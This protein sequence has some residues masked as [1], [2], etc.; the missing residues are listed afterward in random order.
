MTPKFIH[1]RTHSAYSVLEGAMK[2]GK[3]VKRIKALN[4]P[5]V[6]VTD[7]GNLYCGMDFSHEAAD[8]GI[9]PILGT[10]LLLK[11]PLEKSNSLI[12]Q[13]DAEPVLD[14][15]VLLVQNEAGYKNLLKIFQRYYMGETKQETP[16][17][18]VEELIE[19]NQGLILL[20]GGATGPIGRYILQGKPEKAKELTVRLKE[21]FGNRFYM[22]VSRTGEADE[23]KTEATFLDLAYELEI[24]LVAT[25]EAFYDK[26][27]MYEAHDA[28]MC[29]G[30]KTY[31]EVTDRIR[32]S[33]QHYLKSADE[34]A[35]LFSDLPEA[36]EN[37]VKIAQRC[38]FMVEFH[39]PE[40]PRYDCHG[41]TEDEVLKATNFIEQ[42]F[43]SKIL[44]A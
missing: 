2:M 44:L 42:F 40:F 43:K 17:L 5:A 13:E 15:I 26:P 25:N 22:E 11:Q 14:K 3:L 12:V 4:M 29:I 38:G 34:M 18:L 39:P 8:N 24:P 20:S 33:A 7:S 41:K 35:E 28:L 27:E 1:L 37:T 31:V 21:A 23:E 19:F 32:L 10:Q 16:H 30:Q 36:L 9:Q 6:A